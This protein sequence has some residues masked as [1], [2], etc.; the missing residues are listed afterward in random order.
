MVSYVSLLLPAALIVWFNP[1]SPTRPNARH[2]DF[3]RIGDADSS[4]LRYGLSMRW[5]RGSL[6]LWGWRAVRMYCQYCNTRS[7][8]G[9][10]GT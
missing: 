2:A 4:G 7:A 8:H 1:S 3:W 9:A 10:T 6:R 5:L